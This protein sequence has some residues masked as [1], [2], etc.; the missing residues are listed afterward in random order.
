MLFFRRF[1]STHVWRH[2]PNSALEY[3]PIL[4]RPI[5]PNAFSL[6]V[7][8]MCQFPLCN[9]HFIFLSYCFI[10]YYCLSCIY[11]HC[12]DFTGISMASALCRRCLNKYAECTTIAEIAY[13]GYPVMGTSC[14]KV[15]KLNYS[16]N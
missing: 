8:L 16:I 1:L 7:L 15:V 4:S 6:H 9:C 12:T 5:R 10:L 11:V 2:M 3:R 14:K 13:V